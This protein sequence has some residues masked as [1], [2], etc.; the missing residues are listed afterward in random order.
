MDPLL[1]IILVALFSLLF[2]SF[3]SVVI[4][5]VPKGGSI[6]SPGSHCPVCLHRLGPLDL[7]P[8]LSWL[9]A[10][11][12][13]RYCSDKMP[14]RYLLLELLVPALMLYTAFLR[15]PSL[16]FVRD[17]IFL[18]LL[19]ILSFIDLDTMELPHKFTV[20][21][22]ISGLLFTIFGVVP[23]PDFAWSHALVG[24]AVGYMLP[25]LL[26]LL[27][28]LARKRDGMGGGDFVLLAMIGA[29]TGPSGVLVAFLVAV[30]IGA[31]VGVTI[32]VRQK[33]IERGA[34][35]IPFGPYL[36]IGGTVTLFWGATIIDIYLRLAGLR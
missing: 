30:F 24:M 9:F 20:T 21:G 31:V 26:S 13:C 36:A 11:G 6:V 8:V 23:D 3:F 10:K 34:L 18:S 17:A 35:A 28:R 15:G 22:M 7:V 25:S 5:R 27:Y 4:A 29:H 33:G 19:V 16:L 2:A 32:M 12:R 1:F 14:F